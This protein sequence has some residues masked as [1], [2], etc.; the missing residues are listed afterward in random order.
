MDFQLVQLFPRPYAPAGNGKSGVGKDFKQGSGGGGVM[1][2]N[3][4]RLRAPHAHG[5][6]VDLS[7]GLS[8]PW[9]RR[10]AGPRLDRVRAI[11]WARPRGTDTEK[12]QSGSSGTETIKE[13]E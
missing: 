7:E 10:R 8:D 6:L 2:F 1:D 13:R 5:D 12:S 11:S 4:E 9:E 3:S